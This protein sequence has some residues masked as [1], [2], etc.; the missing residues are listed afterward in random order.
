MTQSLVEQEMTQ[1]LEEM[2][3]T[4]LIPVEVKTISQVVMEQT[5]SK[6]EVEMT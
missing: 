1:F 2:E 5:P 6:L 3:M 4:P